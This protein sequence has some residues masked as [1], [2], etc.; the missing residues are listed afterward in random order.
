MN[1]IIEVKNLKKRY[2]NIVAVDDI[3]FNVKE[4]DLFAFLGPNGAGKSTVI[5]ILCTI[6]EKNHGEVIIDKKNLDKEPAMIRNKIGVVFQTNILDDLL[7]VKENLILRGS[8]YDMKK[9]S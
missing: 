3:S 5:N 4:G 6:L 9:R 2:G 7:T 8:L 1:D